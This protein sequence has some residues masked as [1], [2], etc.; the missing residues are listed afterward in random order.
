MQTRKFQLISLPGGHT[1][2]PL[3]DEDPEPSLLPLPVLTS[4]ATTE[5]DATGATVVTEPVM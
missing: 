3:D 1:H 4:A 5:A 2:E